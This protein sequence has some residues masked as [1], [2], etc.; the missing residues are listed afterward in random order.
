LGAI[1][2]S[3]HTQGGYSLISIRSFTNSLQARHF[4]DCIDGKAKA[5]MTVEPAA[6]HLGI[7]FQILGV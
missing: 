1:A 5:M 3:L 6:K 2:K 4:L 7:L